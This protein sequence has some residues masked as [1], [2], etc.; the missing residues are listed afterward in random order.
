MAAT[1]RSPAPRP[2]EVAQEVVTVARVAVLV[3]HLDLPGP[4][5]GRQAGSHGV[6][7]ETERLLQEPLPGSDAA[8]DEPRGGVLFCA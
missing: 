7:V 2:G 8:G 4:A 5:Q 3:V 6:A 1:S